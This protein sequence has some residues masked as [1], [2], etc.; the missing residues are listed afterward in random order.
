MTYDI[1]GT[2]QR[3]N[4]QQSH[5]DNFLINVGDTK[6]MT[7]RLHKRLGPNKSEYVPQSKFHIA[8]QNGT[9]FRLRYQ[10]EMPDV[11]RYRHDFPS[12]WKHEVDLCKMPGGKANPDPIA[13]TMVFR[14][15]KNPSRV[16]RDTN[17]L[18]VVQQPEKL[19]A[20]FDKHKHMLTKDSHKRACREID[21]RVCKKF[22]VS[23]NT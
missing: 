22:K 12:N 13:L 11:K 17:K 23:R 1:D 14:V 20:F 7:F 19:S 3:N 6:R 8:L 18:V 4:H 16:Y 2:V 9:L 15:G 21:Q 10:D 5:T